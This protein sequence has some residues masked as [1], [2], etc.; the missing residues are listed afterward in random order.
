MTVLKNKSR[1]CD[2]LGSRLDLSFKPGV[3]VILSFLPCK[4]SFVTSTRKEK[5]KD[6]QINNLFFCRHRNCSQSFVTLQELE[7]HMTKGIHQVPTV[8]SGIDLVKKIIF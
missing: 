3:Q 6:Q 8:K 2:T 1:T 7:D 4:D 5:Q